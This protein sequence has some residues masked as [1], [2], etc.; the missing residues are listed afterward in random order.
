MSPFRVASSELR[1][2]SWAR[3]VFRAA[4]A[5]LKEYS[6]LLRAPVAALS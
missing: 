2:A 6:A 3:A 5:W 4:V 1:V